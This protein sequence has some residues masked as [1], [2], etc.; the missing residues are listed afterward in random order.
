MYDPWTLVGLVYG[1]PNE[2]DDIKIIE[3]SPS[4]PCY[5]KCLR[6][7]WL[8]VLNTT[9]SLKRSAHL[10]TS[11]RLLPSLHERDRLS[12]LPSE[13][14]SRGALSPSCIRNPWLCRLYAAPPYVHN[15]ASLP[16]PPT[17]CA[18]LTTTLRFQVSSLRV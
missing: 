14:Y 10:H 18:L 2:S 11:L 8:Q 9:F 13:R 3:A 16:F 7:R 15:G 12:I 4:Y 17:T 6:L 1:N 5:L